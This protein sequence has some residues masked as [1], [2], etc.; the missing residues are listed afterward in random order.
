MAP[1][2][3]NR[4]GWRGKLI[5]VAASLRTIA[6]ATPKSFATLVGRSPALMAA[7]IMFALA[8]GISPIGVA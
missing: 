4:P 6:T 3:P 8:G 7:R 2:F 5:H 1:D